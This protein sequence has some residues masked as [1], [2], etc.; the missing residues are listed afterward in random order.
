MWKLSWKASPGMKMLL[1]KIYYMSDSAATSYG[2]A[3]KRI[4]PTKNIAV[5]NFY[6]VLMRV[7]RRK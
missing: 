1:C 5:L 4:F 3:F 2:V 7:C 6:H